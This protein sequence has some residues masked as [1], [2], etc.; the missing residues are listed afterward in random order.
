MTA[1]QPLAK[2]HTSNRHAFA[3][4]MGDDAIAI[5]DTADV[6]GYLDNELPF[7]PDPN[8]YYLTGIDEPEAVLVLV[9]GHSNPE[10]RELL[11]TSGTNQHVSIWEGER[12]TTEQATRVS[13]L[14]QVLPLSEL[15]F[16]LGRLLSKFQT[17]FLNAEESLSGSLTSP[18]IRRARQLREN[19]PLHQLRSAL[20]QLGLQRAVKAPEEVELIR[21]AISIT[22]AGL[23]N[24]WQVLKPGCHENDLV[25]ELTAEFIRRGTNH[26]FQPIVASG[27]ASTIIHYMKNLAQVGAHD[28][29]LFDVGA[30]SSYY[31][32]DIS[33]TLPASGQFT[34]RQRAVYEA[35]LKAQNAGIEHTQ[36]GESVL[37]IDEKMQTVLKEEIQ[38]LGLTDNFRDYYPHISHHLGLDTHDTGDSRLV[39]EPG[40]VI[41]CEPG[42]YLRDEGIGVRLEDDILITKDGCEVLSRDI[43]R[44]PDA[45]EAVFQA[46]DK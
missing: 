30:Q 45:V 4:A 32:A 27:Q 42:L 15:E 41:T 13:G 40:M 25:A 6:L 46:R 20:P 19:S 23:R 26:G 38:K 24:A 11:F 10:A 3:K 22:A 35:V 9:P 31:N 2:F 36:P 28:L 21:G 5:I 33:R 12:L 37:S 29:V 16:Y 43:P 1:T 8:F 7:R 14:K 39:L 18:S 34:D 17:V 44:S